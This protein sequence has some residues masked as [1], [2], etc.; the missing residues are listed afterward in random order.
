VAVIENQRGYQR[1]MFTVS[2]VHS[3]DHGPGCS[4][5]GVRNW[6]Q[7]VQEGLIGCPFQDGTKKEGASTPL[8]HLEALR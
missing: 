2:P 4:V 7:S 8:G 1:I 5:T 3:R 6:P